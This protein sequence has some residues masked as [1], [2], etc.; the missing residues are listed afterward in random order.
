MNLSNLN[1]QELSTK[2]MRVVEG[3]FP[4]LILAAW[5]VM[6]VCSAVALGMKEALDEHNAKR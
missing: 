2:E 4:P 5:G 3:G 6:A 1:V